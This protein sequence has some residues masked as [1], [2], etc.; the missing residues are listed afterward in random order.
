MNNKI[1]LK[2]FIKFLRREN[3]YENYIEGLKRG[4]TYRANCSRMKERD[5]LKW[6]VKTIKVCPQKLIEDAFSWSHY[7]FEDWININ[8]KWKDY[9]YSKKDDKTFNV[10]KFIKDAEEIKEFELL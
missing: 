10:E 2:L 9:F 1:I 4:A 8:R 5:E 7:N 3:I 6:L